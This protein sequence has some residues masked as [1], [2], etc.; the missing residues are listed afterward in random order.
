MEL[1]LN[2]TENLNNKLNCNHFTIMRR[3]N[4]IKYCVG[5]IFRVHL[6]GK[7]KGR[8]KIIG[9]RSFELDKITD[10]VSYLDMG[11]RAEVCRAKIKQ[12]YKKYPYI[13]WET[14]LLDFCLLEYDKK[15]CEPQ[16]F[17]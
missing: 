4:P 12:A 2:F 16:L 7:Y 9:V 1:E 11:C 5:A 15:E 13:K 14:E 17:G 6:N 8:A 3:H 10:F